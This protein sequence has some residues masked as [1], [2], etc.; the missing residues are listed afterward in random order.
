MNSMIDV[1]LVG[2]ALLASAVY[3]ISSLGPRSLKPRVLL[4]LSRYLASAPAFMGLR[5]FAQRLR[6]AA[7][8]KT[9][10]ACGGCDSCETVEVSAQQAS[11]AEVLVPVTKIG[12]RT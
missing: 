3:V 2:V 4:T 5:P 12:R 6:E 8:A 7:A 1:S 10:G 9:N 11:S